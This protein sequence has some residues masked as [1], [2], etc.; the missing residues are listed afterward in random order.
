[1]DGLAPAAPDAR[2]A[3]GRPAEPGGALP[4]RDPLLLAEGRPGRGRP[5]PPG[6]PGRPRQPLRPVRPGV[7]DVHPEQG[8]VHA[9]RQRRL[10]GVR[11]RTS[12]AAVLLHFG[13]HGGAPCTQRPAI[14][15][16]TTFATPIRS[17]CSTMSVSSTTRSAA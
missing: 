9:H 10:I 7:P 14:I 12:G 1:A 5:V 16:A 17:G 3:A 11:P 6:R 13:H 4:P 15:V 8:G 2:D